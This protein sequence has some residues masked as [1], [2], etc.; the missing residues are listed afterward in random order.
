M[1]DYI[2]RLAGAWLHRALENGEDEAYCRTMEALL[3][4]AQL[5]SQHMILEDLLDEIITSVQSVTKAERVC[6][7]MFDDAE[8]ELWLA[9]SLN[10]GLSTG[11][12]SCALCS[13]KQRVCVKKMHARECV[14]WA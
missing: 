6:L 4:L 13:T 2:V 3:S 12:P 1:L 11:E 8:D 9:R 7:Y 14:T 10:V 5:S